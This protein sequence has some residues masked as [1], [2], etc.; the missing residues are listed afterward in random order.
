MF[1]FSHLVEG[2]Q[3]ACCLQPALHVV[4]RFI[5]LKY[6]SVQLPRSFLEGLCGWAGV[7]LILGGQIGAGEEDWNTGAWRG[8]R[9]KLNGPCKPN[10]KSLQKTNKQTNK[11]KLWLRKSQEKTV[12]NVRAEGSH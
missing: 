9:G 11:H 6:S 3:L 7:G 8:S 2:S 4:V 10:Q 12:P 5:S 1:R